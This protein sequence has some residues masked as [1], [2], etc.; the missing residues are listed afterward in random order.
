M[1]TPTWQPRL[2]FAPGLALAAAFVLAGTTSLAGCADSQSSDD[3]AVAG[4]I[5]LASSADGTTLAG[6]D[7]GSGD[8]V[9]ITLPKGD[10][11]WV[12]A[13]RADVLAA[14]LANGTIA[15]SDPVHLGK[16]L[17]WRAIKAV[18]PTGDA[19]KGPYYFA[20]WDPGGGRFA[21]LAGD[22]AS[23][24]DIRVILVD[25]SVA[26]AFE[27]P[28]DRPVVAAPPVWIDDDRLVIV[29]GDASEPLTTTI[30]ATTGA[31]DDGP[32]GARLLAASANGRRIAT[33]AGQGAPVV[34]RD[35]A[36]WLNGDGSSVASIDPPSGRATAIGFALDATGQRVVIAW[37]TDGKTVS[38][39]VHEERAGWRRLAEPKIGAAKG[40]VVAWRR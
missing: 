17:K 38:L 5:A 26:S 7:A 30:D 24:E 3:A 14:V 21:M 37:A 28:I 4:L 20:T 36:G 29:T 11:T 39:A 1:P 8:G 19:P 34:I 25:P 6:W 27:I 23:G 2:R 31:L 33:M 12:G 40:A 16:P 35:T 15:T 9:A 32:S 13:G 22:L 18:G 10:A